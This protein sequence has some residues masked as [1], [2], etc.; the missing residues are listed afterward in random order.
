MS[1]NNN[2]A[3]YDI[4]RMIW[5]LSNTLVKNRNRKLYALDL[6][7]VQTEVMVF[8]LKNMD[9]EEIN[10]LDIQEHLMLTNPAVTGILKRMEE[11]DLIER[12]QSAKDA[13]YNNIKPTQKGFELKKILIDNMSKEEA[14]MTQG[15]T[16]KEQKDFVSLLH[17]ALK[18]MED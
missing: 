11:K 2:Y 4:A 16:A 5:Q 7:S 3:A 17:I 12:L 15:M 18:N 1:D 8:L 6:T 14:R 10:Q 9:K 13:R